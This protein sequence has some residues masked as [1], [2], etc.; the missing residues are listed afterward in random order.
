MAVTTTYVVG[1]GEALNNVDVGKKFSKRFKIDTSDTNVASGEI[2]KLMEVPI[3]LNIEDVIADVTTAEGG[4]LTIDIGDYL[5]A[6]DSAV[7]A[8]GYHD[9]LNGN[10]V[11]VTKTS[12]QLAEDT[13]AIAYA[14]GKY[15]N[16]HTAYIGILFNN[17]ADA[18]ILDVTILG[19]DCR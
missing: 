9:G 8:D 14:A 18:A 4:T 5:I 15:Y 2:V 3:N 10:S 13:T 12:D 16:A 17:A 19:T 1:D 6:D 11:A 7:D